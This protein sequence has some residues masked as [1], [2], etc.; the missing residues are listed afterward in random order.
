MPVDA[1]SLTTVAK[2]E[3]YL[4]IAAGTDTSLLEASIDAAS[5]QIEQMLGRVIKSRDLYEWQ[6][7]DRTP[8]IGVKTRPI[9]H[10]KYVAFGS[11]NAIE[12][13]P[14]SGS[15]DV[16]A[17]VE[18]TTSHVRLFRVDSTGQSHQTQV[19]FANHQTT[20]EVA[21]AI[22]AV[23]G[24][25]ATAVDEYSAY[26]LHPRAGVNVLDATGY[27]TAAWDTTADLRVDHETGIISF[28]SDGW[29][30]DHWTTEFPASPMSILIAYNGGYDTV[31]YDIEQV[32][33]E[34]AGQL[35]RDRKRD[36]GVQSESLGDYSYSL[37]S[38]SAAAASDLIRT[39]L[40]SRTRIR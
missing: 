40:G 10:V 19:Q 39:R 26:Q 34:V 8:Q 27:L 13:R 16:L 24:F 22:A 15:T 17:T 36:R 5:V 32:C 1:N 30:S 11:N 35:Y 37:A 4:G 29:P 21:T 6:N 38:G 3:T 20:T 23:T 18:V 7:S 12:V 14:A 33:L 9:N 2:L 28:I 31:P 25:D